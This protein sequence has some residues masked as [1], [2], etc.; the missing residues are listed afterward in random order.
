[1]NN[2]KM[3]KELFDQLEEVRQLRF[4]HSSNLSQIQHWVELFMRFDDVEQFRKFNMELHKFL[5]TFSQSYTKS[6]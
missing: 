5:F 6:L 3:T 4:E 2:L 1:M